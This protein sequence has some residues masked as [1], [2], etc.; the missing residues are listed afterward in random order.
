MKKKEGILTQSNATQEFLT[1]PTVMF[2][3]KLVPPQLMFLADG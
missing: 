3:L 1:T 2:Q